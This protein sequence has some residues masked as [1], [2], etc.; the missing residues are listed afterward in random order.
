MDDQIREY[1]IYTIYD[2]VA[3]D[4]APIF[5]AKNESVAIRQYQGLLYNPKNPSLFPDEYQLL[6]VGIC[7]IQNG[8][9]ELLSMDNLEIKTTLKTE[10]NNESSI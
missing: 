7:K 1:G 3:D 9:V 4:Y 8:R 5:E 2:K 10:V 6:K